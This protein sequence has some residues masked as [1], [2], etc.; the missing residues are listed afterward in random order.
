MARYEK[1]F[2]EGLG[3]D[4]GK[5][6][7]ITEMP[8]RRGHEWATR[9]ILAMMSA[10]AEI[11]DD[12]QAGGMAA[13]AVLGLTALGKAPP[14]IVLP[15]LN[16]LLGCVQTVFPTAT[17]DYIDDDF[18]EI[19]TIFQLQKAAFLLHTEPFTSGGPSTSVQATA[20]T[21]A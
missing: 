5:K 13:L 1:V 4:A 14:Q 16:E 9:A 8:P 21:P 20:G 12:L 10:G 19:S 3:R 18:E 6:F 17:R 2:A 11:P 15:L 7:L